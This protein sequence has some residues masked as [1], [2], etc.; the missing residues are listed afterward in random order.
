VSEATAVR[1]WRGGAYHWREYRIDELLP[2]A[3]DGRRLLLLGCGD[4]GERPYLQALGFEPVGLDVRATAGANVVGDAHALPFDGEVFDL[5][6]SMQVL[7][8]L[9]SPWVAVR[10]IARV[11]RPGGV[12]VGS[13]AFLKPY[14]GSYFHM[15]HLGVQQLLGTAGLQVDKLMGAQSIAYSVYGSMFPWLGRPIRRALFGTVDELLSRFR[16][17]AWSLTR[18]RDPDTE[19]DRF[20]N[21]LPLSFRGFDKLR[22]APSVVFRARK[23]QGST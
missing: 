12:F 5:V 16:V 8:H 14:H 2:S 22:F 20:G 23:G 21:G 13:V 4:A 9:H 7:E 15:T 18:R 11:L 3:K 6:L 10:E 17:L 19:T 1:R